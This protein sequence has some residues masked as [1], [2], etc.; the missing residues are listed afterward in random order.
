MANRG[1]AWPP[2]Y[3]TRV[4]PS[5][6]WPRAQYGKGSMC[7]ATA[8]P[9]NCT[10]EYAAVLPLAAMTVS[11]IGSITASSRNATPIPQPFRINIGRQ[12]PARRTAS[13]ILHRP[14]SNSFVRTA[15]L[16][17]DSDPSRS[18]RRFSRDEHAADA[19]QDESA[20]PQRSLGDRK[21]ERSGKATWH[22]PSPAM[23]PIEKT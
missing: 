3:E 15:D 13:H 6:S 21:S 4:G 11:L 9:P 8:E 1:T 17:F 7:W 14:V 10:P 2:P 18:R 23:F 5:L 19:R 16:E 20:S 12:H 22:G